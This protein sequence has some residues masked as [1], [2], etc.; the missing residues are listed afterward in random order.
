MNRID[1]LRQI[2]AIWENDHA[3]LVQAPKSSHAVATHEYE[4]PDVC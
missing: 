3:L 1:L 2:I 4:I